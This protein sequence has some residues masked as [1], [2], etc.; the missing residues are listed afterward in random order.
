VTVTIEVPVAGHTGPRTDELPMAFTP[1][2]F[3]RGALATYGFFLAIS[4]GVWIWTLIG[5]LVALYYVAPFG[6]ASLVFVGAPLALLTGTLLRR[7]TRTGVHLLWHGLVGLV[8]GGAG[9]LFA[10]CIVGPS[11]IWSFSAPHLPDFSLLA[12]V[13]I[14]AVMEALFTV[15][16]AM[17]GWRYTSRKALRG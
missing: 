5:S 1:W 13:W 12:P 9:V 6:F 16:A 17:L 4:A 7:E 14:L 11:D 8:A 10:L 3:I 2:E 15:G